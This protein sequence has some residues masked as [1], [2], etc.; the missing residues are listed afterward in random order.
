[1]YPK[2][3]SSSTPDQVANLKHTEARHGCLASASSWGNG[4]RPR[5]SAEEEKL[6]GRRNLSGAE[7][8]YIL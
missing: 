7:R 5:P 2:A 8:V 4:D 6:I 3:G 1:M